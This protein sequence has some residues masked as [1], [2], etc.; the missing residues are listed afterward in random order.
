[1]QTLNKGNP[2]MHSRIELQNNIDSEQFET[3]FNDY[4]IGIAFTAQIH[5]PNGNYDTDVIPL[6]D[7]PGGD[8]AEVVDLDEWKEK[9]SQDIRPNPSGTIL[10]SLRQDAV[11]FLS[12]AKKYL[13]DNYEFGNAGSMF[14]LTRNRHGAGFWDGYKHGKEL[15]DLAHTFGSAEIVAYPRDTAP[16]GLIY[17]LVE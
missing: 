6:F 10:D 13:T 12:Q 5:R 11:E 15:T 14:H 3:F 2:S 7:N 8:I 9:L 17:N 16:Y 1:M 4:L